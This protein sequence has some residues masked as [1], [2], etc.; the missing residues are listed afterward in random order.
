MVNFLYILF[1]LAQ[2]VHFSP[3]FLTVYELI[4]GEKTIEEQISS[5][6]VGT[7][8]K[9]TAL[10][11]SQQDQRGGKFLFLNFYNCLII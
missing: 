10:K 7:T 3:H 1:S 4:L 8:S 11:P 5:N 9:S 2:L 6:Y